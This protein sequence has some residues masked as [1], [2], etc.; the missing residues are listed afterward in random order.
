MINK[1]N[2]PWDWLPLLF[3]P[4]EAEPIKEENNIA[5]SESETDKLFGQQR[6]RERV[7]RHLQQVAILN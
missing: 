7:E 4:V 2:Q 5:I 3:F 1:R 6:D